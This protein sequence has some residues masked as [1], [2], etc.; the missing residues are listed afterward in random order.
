M[1]LYKDAKVKLEI[2][3]LKRS[4]S[5]YFAWS[6]SVKRY[7]NRK[8]ALHFVHKSYNKVGIAAADSTRPK[9]TLLKKQATKKK[10]PQTPYLSSNALRAFFEL[11]ANCARDKIVTTS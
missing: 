6:E 11:S 2:V 5:N 7:L 3:L 10:T 1:S 4:L 8:G 9:H